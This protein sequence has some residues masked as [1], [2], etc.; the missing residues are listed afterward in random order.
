MKI[1]FDFI[2][3]WIYAIAWALL[4]ISGFSMVGA[5]NGWILNFDYGMADY[6][7][8]ISAGFFVLITFISIFHEVYRSLKSDTKYLAW[9]VIGRSGY[10]LFTFIVTLIL[11][12][13]GALIWICSELNLSIAGF[14]L[15]IH[16]YISYIALA[17]IIWHIYMKCHALIW[18][19][20]KGD[21]TTQGGMK[22]APKTVD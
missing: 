11:I 22:D 16:E 5:K 10:Q 7:H 2:M 19:K 12:I 20:K 13:T 15:I 14:A 6:V 8:R 1:R 17:S 21:Q 3:H 4:G 18:P 9:N